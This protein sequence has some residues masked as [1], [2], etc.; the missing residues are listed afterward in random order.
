MNYLFSLMRFAYYVIESDEARNPIEI[1]AP[2][3]TSQQ[4]QAMCEALF[5]TIVTGFTTSIFHFQ[6]LNLKFNAIASLLFSC[7]LQHF[8]LG[9][10]SFEINAYEPENN[11]LQSE[12]RFKKPITITL[13]Y[14][15]EQMLKLNERVVS[16]EV[17]K[18]DIDPVLLLWDKKNQTW[19]LYRNITMKIKRTAYLS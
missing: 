12:Y 2:Y 15:V 3:K 5:R 17:T 6:W 13:V 18:E 19:Y 11:T 7:V 4:K 9:N 1:L 8:K 14:D 16:D 10:Y